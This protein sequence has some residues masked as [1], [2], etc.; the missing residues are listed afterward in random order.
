MAEQAVLGKGLNCTPAPSRIPIR[1]VA[2]MESGLKRLPEE[3]AEAPRTM[4]VGAITKARA[5]W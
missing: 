4:V 1:I 3:L 2:A 5:P